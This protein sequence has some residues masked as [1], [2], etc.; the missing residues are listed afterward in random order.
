MQTWLEAIKA[1]MIK[2]KELRLKKVED[3]I[4]TGIY[5][6]LGQWRNNRH[7]ALAG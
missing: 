6:T 4:N 5:E 7:D 3:I 2:E 1:A